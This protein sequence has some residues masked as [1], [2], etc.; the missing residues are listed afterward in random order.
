MW[1]N[2]LKLIKDPKENQEIRGD[3]AVAAILV[4]AAKTDGIYT[5]SE[6][7]LIE[8]LLMQQ[9][10][11][12]K[13]KVNQLQISAEA[14]EKE[15]ND[16]VQL[17]RVIKKEIDYD[18]RKELVQQLWQI[19]MDDDVRTPEENKFMRVLTNLLGVNDVESAKARSKAIKLLEKRT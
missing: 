6:Q 1:N 10:H 2:L 13:E 5:N 16:N 17:T 4:R 14:L 9:M 18:D 11:V 8:K 7:K 15:I 12:P 19:I 3:E